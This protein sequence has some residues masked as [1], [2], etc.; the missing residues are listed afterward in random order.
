[1][2]AYTI[3]K[4]EESPIAPHRLFKALV[5]ERHQ[6]LVKAQPHVFKSGEIVEG[7]GGVGTVTKIT[8]VDGHPFTYMLHKFDEIDAA[9]FYC[10]YTLFEGD[11]LRD[12][13]EKVVYEVKLE[14]VG[15]GSKGKITVTYHPKPGCTV[16][17]EEVKI[18][19]KKAYEFY[20]QVEE[21]LAANPEVF[22]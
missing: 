14:S 12:N 7:D 20:K 22:A 4:E 17:E 2:A 9:N 21:Y 6:V 13:I 5:L 18:G 1:M 3:V 15:G 10:K 19:E 8:F 16:N 11:V